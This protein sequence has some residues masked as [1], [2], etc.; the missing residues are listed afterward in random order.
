MTYT[1]MAGCFNRL[2]VLKKSGESNEDKVRLA[3]A[4]F[5]K[6]RVDHLRVNSGKYSAPTK[7]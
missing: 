1:R 2:K 3:T 6:I 5:N 7:L 4:L